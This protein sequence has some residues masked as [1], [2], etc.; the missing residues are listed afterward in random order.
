[1]FEDMAVKHE[2]AD[3]NLVRHA[4]RNLIGRIGET[5]D[6]ILGGAYAEAVRAHGA[7]C[8]N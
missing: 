3:L 5:T 6:D 7:S 8:S 1:M 2:A 4:R